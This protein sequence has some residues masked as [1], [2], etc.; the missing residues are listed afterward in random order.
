MQEPG[1]RF[2]E[3]F[4]E[5]YEGLPRQGPGNRANA[6]RAL[7]MCTDLPP[8]LDILD[9]GC[10]TGGQSLHLVELTQGTLLGLDS[11]EPSIAR[12]NARLIEL[13]LTSRVRAI[14]A[15]MANPRLDQMFD[16]VWSEGALYNIGIPRALEVC[17]GLMRSEGYLVFTDAVWRRDDPP[18]EVRKAF[19]L[20]Y[21]A[22]GRVADI[23]KAIDDGGFTLIDHFTL[24]DEAWW[25]DFYTP[26]EHRIRQLQQQPRYADDPEAIAALAELAREPE[27]HRQYGDYYGYE[28]FVTRLGTER[29]ENATNPLG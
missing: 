3:V 24:S 12:F 10:G 6:Q 17:R 22:M 9:L 7:A 19:D 1:A 18:P 23:L 28:F 27:M 21:P 8:E 13:G 25:D 29:P 15:D 5:V 16:L 14:T 26:M 4:F 2:R 20:D 11:H